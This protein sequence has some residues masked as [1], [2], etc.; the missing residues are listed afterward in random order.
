MS[1]RASLLA[2]TLLLLTQASA[3]PR[4][5]PTDGSAEGLP[6]AGIS[7]AQREELQRLLEATAAAVHELPAGHESRDRVR[8]LRGKLETLRQVAEHAEEHEWDG[9]LQALLGSSEYG[10]EE[11]APLLRQAGAKTEEACDEAVGADDPCAQR[12][13]PERPRR[14]R[15]AQA[16]PFPGAAAAD[17]GAEEEEQQE[18][19]LQWSER[20]LDAWRACTPEELARQ[21]DEW[22]R[23][24]LDRPP[25]WERDCDCCFTRC[26][27]H[28]HCLRQSDNLFLGCRGESLGEV[29]DRQWTE[30]P[31]TLVGLTLATCAVSSAWL[32]LQLSKLRRSMR[33]GDD[34]DAN[35][36]DANDDDDDDDAPSEPEDGEGDKEN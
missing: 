11:L 3:E 4:P 18:A 14:R 22:R 28:L 35:D 34:D 19:T 10:T 20:L 2:A 29:L 24:F 5:F 27:E 25:P 36:D 7:L 13:Q 23:W 16:W 12:T 32:G 21:R 15:L 1:C 26:P 6:A 33:R 30:R 8:L 17:T 31:W 9:M